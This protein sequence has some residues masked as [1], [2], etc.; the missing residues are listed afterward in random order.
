MFTAIIESDL[1]TGSMWGLAPPFRVRDECRPFAELLFEWRESKIREIGHVDMVIE[2]GET[3]EGPGHKST[4]ELFTTDMEEQAEIAADHICM[5]DCDEFH[6]C[7]ASK[8]HTG[9]DSKT[10]RMVVDKIKLRHNKCAD[11]KVVHRLEV[12]GVKINAAHHVGN[13]RTGHGQFS[14]VGKAA[15]VDYLRGQYRDYDGADL[16]FRAHTHKFVGV[17]DELFAAYNNPS[18]QWPMGE[19]GFKIDDPHYTMGFLELRIA[20]GEWQV[21]PH[22]FKARLPEEEYAKFTRGN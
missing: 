7:Y 17:Q 16:Y 9:N 20:D 4:I 22:I 21:K 14:Q 2:L 11:I 15:V 1:Q 8:Y 18:M 19:Y 12:D 13:S 10:E 5:W 6:I 3:T